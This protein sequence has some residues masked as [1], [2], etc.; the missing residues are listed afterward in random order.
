MRSSSSIQNNSKVEHICRDCPTS[1][2]QG[3]LFIA[4]FGAEVSEENLFNYFSKFGCVGQVKIKRKLN[5][6]TKTSG[7][8]FISIS[9]LTT[10]TDIVSE[11]HYLSGQKIQCQKALSHAEASK[12]KRDEKCRKVFVGGLPRKLSNEQLCHYFKQFGVIEKGYVVKSSSTGVARGFGFVVYKERKSL[13]L[14]LSQAE[15][16]IG[17]KSVRIA[18]AEPNESSVD[19]K[20][21]EIKQGYQSYQ[22]I[23]SENEIKTSYIQSQQCFP[24]S[25]RSKHSLNESEYQNPA[26]EACNFTGSER[27][28]FC[29]VNRLELSNSKG[30]RIPIILRSLKNENLKF[31]ILENHLCTDSVFEEEMRQLTELLYANFHY[32][33]EENDKIDDL[34]NFYLTFGMGSEGTG[35]LSEVVTGIAQREEVQRDN[36]S[37]YYYRRAKLVNRRSIY[38]RGF[39]KF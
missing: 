1:S 21:F 16:I 35:G 6:A 25:K 32:L 27:H 12:R 33:N 28:N 13:E 24:S 37:Q 18:V 15:H 8:G 30:L 17:S 14:A 9:P 23:P 22:S 26:F 10:L 4:G 29:L 38:H 5:D 2:K 3:E 11:E 20:S 7:F 31:Q 34:L 19:F 36:P 39:R